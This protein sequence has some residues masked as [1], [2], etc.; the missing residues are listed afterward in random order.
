[1]SPCVFEAST[2]VEAPVERVFAFHSDPRN[3]SRIAPAWQQAQVIA[4]DPVARPGGRFEIDFA[5]FRVIR[6]RWR[7]RWQEVQ[8]PT[9]LAD[10]GL[11]AGPFAVWRHRHLFRALGPGRTEMTDHVTY[12]LRGG[13]LGKAASETFGR[14]QMRLM[15]ADRHRRTRALFAP[16]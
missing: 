2:V 16:K 13:A 7:G 14:L 11:E 5:M 1:M 9:L 15:F 6:F 3:I 8:S 10:D 4:A 12:L